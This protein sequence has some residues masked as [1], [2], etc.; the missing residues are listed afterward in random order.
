MDM[1]IFQKRVMAS[2]ID[3]V[4]VGAVVFILQF[5]C[6]LILPRFLASICAIV[7]NFIGAGLILLKDGPYKVAFLDRQSIGKKQMYLRVT[8]DDGETSITWAESISRNIPFA[9]PFVLGSLSFAVSMIPFIGWLLLPFVGL[10]SLVSIAF[11]GFETFLMYKD[12]QGK[13]WGD[14]RAGTIVAPGEFT[15]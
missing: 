7:V 11:I 9:I 8:K 6:F 5:P 3:C 10:G 15:S 2:F 13:R 1:E 12:P 14:R 4:M